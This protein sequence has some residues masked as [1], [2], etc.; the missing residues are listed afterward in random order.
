MYTV[1][2][3]TERDT[4]TE[5][6]QVDVVTSTGQRKRFAVCLLLSAFPGYS[7]VERRE[8][9]L[10]MVREMYREE[11]GTIVPANHG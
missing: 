3:A 4:K 6:M 9:M 7:A 2:V 10:E 11:T 5:Q 8:L 1:I